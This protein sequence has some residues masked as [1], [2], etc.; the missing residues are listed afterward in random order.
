VLLRASLLAD[1]VYKTGG[2]NAENAETQGRRIML[3]SRPQIGIKA[4]I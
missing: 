2:R 3:L 4:K 1:H